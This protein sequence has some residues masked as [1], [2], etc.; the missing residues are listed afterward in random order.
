MK[1]VLLIIAIILC[2]FQMVVLATDITIGNTA[3]DRGSYIA[4]NYTR[5]DYIHAATGTGNLTSIEVYLQQA[6]TSD[7]YV[8]TF[9]EVSSDHFTARDN[10]NLGTITVGYH[11]LTTDKNSAAI[12]LSVETGD[13][14]G[15]WCDSGNIEL[16]TS[17]GGF[18]YY[19][20]VSNQTSC[21]NT[22][23]AFLDNRQMSLYASGGGAAAADNAIFIG[24]NF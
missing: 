5:I 16:D 23:F 18:Y 15:I 2:I 24:T 17:G 13:Y 3:S 14:I 21:V 20:A 8:A 10:V 22:A 1:K 6:T 7:V 19:P 12:S 11:K 4:I 9:E